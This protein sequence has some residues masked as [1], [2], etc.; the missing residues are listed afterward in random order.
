MLV[1]VEVSSVVM[2]ESVFSKSKPFVVVG[3][4]AFNEEKSIARV[5]LEAQ[6]FSDVV[7][8]CDDG[9]KDFTARIAER[10]GADIG[11]VTRAMGLDPRIGRS[12]L[13]AGLGFGGFCLPKDLQAFV[14]LA[15]RSGVDFSMLKEAERINRK[16]QQGRWKP[17]V[18]L[19][20]SVSHAEVAKLY[21][22]ADFCMVTSLHDGMNLVAKEFVAARED[23]LGVLILSTFTGASR[24]LQDALL[25]NPYDTP[26][27]AEAIRQAVEM[28]ESEQRQ[29]MH[30][31]RREVRENNIYKWAANFTGEL[32][33]L[34]MER[35]QPQP[36]PPEKAVLAA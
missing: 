10:L 33:D 12:F 7:V 24:E 19:N 32:A 2:D 5:V 29:R 17:I 15:E 18:F 11:E 28:S 9:S 22:A 1:E 26:Q 23:E 20:R 35:T 4:P 16:Y 36:S 8:V 25:V 27:L 30:E 31:M 3:I 6:R 34:R 14:H 21:H 13:S